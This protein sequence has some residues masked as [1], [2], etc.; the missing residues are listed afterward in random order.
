VAKE[1]PIVLEV[2]GREVR[3]TSPGRVYFPD[4]GITKLDVVRYYQAVAEGALRGIARR[5]I[6][7]K[8]Y[9]HGITGDFFFQKRAPDKRPSWIETVQLRFPSG[10][11]ADEVVVSEL[12]QLLWSGCPR[13]STGTRSPIAS[14][15]TSR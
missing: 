12:P 5:P 10:R 8:R 2:G 11:S 9:V 7:L 6:V 15:H 4:A 3:V 13:R 1:K 14:F